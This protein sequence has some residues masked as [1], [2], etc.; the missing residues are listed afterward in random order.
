MNDKT[1]A[2][3]YLAAAGAIF[4]IASKLL[5]RP[6]SAALKHP[7]RVACLGDSLT[8]AGLYCS[9]LAGIL[10][11]DT[12]AF[13]YASQGVGVVGSHVDDVLAWNPDVVVVLAGVNDLPSS[14][15]AARVIAG[16][17][18]IYSQLHMK[19]VSVV[20]VE[21]VPWYGYPSAA[22]HETNTE[23]VNNWIR[24]KSNVEA[25]VKTSMLGDYRGNL[26]EMYDSGD[27]LHLNREGQAQLAVL[28]A[29]Q[30][31]GK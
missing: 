1:Q 9:D 31:F 28:I 4:L 15:G 30:A 11:C 26:K 6:K 23:I 7:Q 14:G 27:H 12:K 29:D 22:G 13:G 10:G 19:D 3:L 18:N 24:H 20:A 25:S 17:T 5:A 21:I 2:L 8:A 16:L